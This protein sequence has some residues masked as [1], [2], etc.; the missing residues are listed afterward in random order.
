MKINL[1]DLNEYTDL[2]IRIAFDAVIGISER[3]HCVTCTFFNSM[4]DEFQYLI[5]ILLKQYKNLNERPPQHFRLFGA[6]LSHID[7]QVLT[8]CRPK[9]FSERSL[10]SD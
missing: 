4:I 3:S 10:Q 6:P 2:N 5:Y 7:Q 8:R 1:L 9:I